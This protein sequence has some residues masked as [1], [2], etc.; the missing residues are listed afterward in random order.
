MK[1]IQSKE[2]NRENEK[3]TQRKRKEYIKKTEILIGS[4][5]N[6]LFREDGTVMTQLKISAGK[7]YKISRVAVIVG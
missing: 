7:V 5:V 1:K 4:A 6:S 3:N 2:I